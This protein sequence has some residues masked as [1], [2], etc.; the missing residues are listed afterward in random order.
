M[1]FMIWDKGVLDAQVVRDECNA[2]TGLHGHANTARCAAAALQKH[3]TS[4]TGT[5]WTNYEPRFDA[6]GLVELADCLRRERTCVTSAHEEAPK[7]GVTAEAFTASGTAGHGAIEHK[8][9]VYVGRQADAMAE[10]EDG[11]LDDHISRVLHGSDPTLVMR[12]RLKARL[13]LEVL[14]VM[15]WCFFMLGTEHEQQ[16]TNA[17]RQPL[18]S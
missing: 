5:F 4:T 17:K 13:H 16:R 6:N 7:E 14:R 15:S 3:C 8:D 11:A 12:L 2:H 10:S 1:H 18:N 9:A